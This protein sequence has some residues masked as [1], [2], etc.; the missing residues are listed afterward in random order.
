ML[1]AADAL[2]GGGGRRPPPSLTHLYHEYVMQRIEA[3]KNSVTRDELMRMAG[4]ATDG[5]YE[6]D[7][8]QFVLTELLTGEV[9]DQ[10]IRKKL[11]LKSPK[12]YGQYILKL[13]AAQKEPT[14]WGLDGVCPGRSAAAT[15]RSQRPR[16]GGRGRR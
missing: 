10:L 5:L 4:E 12:K 14:H 2:R 7:D 8:S 16:P 15:S 11:K 3:F 9:V 6:S 1:T 13:R